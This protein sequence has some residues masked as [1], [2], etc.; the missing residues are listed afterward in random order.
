M[1]PHAAES[2]CCGGAAALLPG[3]QLLLGA[4]PVGLLKLRR[5]KS[6]WRHAQQ[7]ASPVAAQLPCCRACGRCSNPKPSRSVFSEAAAQKAAAPRP[8]ERQPCSGAAQVGH[9]AHCAFALQQ[10]ATNNRTKGVRQVCTCG[11]MPAYGGAAWPHGR[12]ICPRL[13]AKPQRHRYT[14]AM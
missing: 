5:C 13:V 10:T 7:G 3:V 6:S 11:R 1:A 9:M 12:P 4:R 2:Q 8:V 14:T